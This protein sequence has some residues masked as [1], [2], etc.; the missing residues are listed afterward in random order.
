VF[1]AEGAYMSG[2]ESQWLWCNWKAFILWLCDCRNKDLQTRWAT[3][4]EMFD[5][6]FPEVICTHCMILDW[7]STNWWVELTGYYDICSIGKFC[8]Q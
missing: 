4:W 8:L 2:E 7:S 3:F 6:I 5:L 1:L